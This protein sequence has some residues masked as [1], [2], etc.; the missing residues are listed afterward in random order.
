MP[1][2]LTPNTP[3]FCTSPTVSRDTLIQQG[4]NLRRSG[5]LTRERLPFNIDH[6]L[7]SHTSGVL[8][9]QDL[10]NLGTID[11]QQRDSWAC[12]SAQ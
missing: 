1:I 5:S 8:C 6:L 3:G 9:L 12:R 4:V 11:H 2:R 7:N 10:G